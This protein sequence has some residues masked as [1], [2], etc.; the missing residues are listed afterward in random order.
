ML[1]GFECPSYSRIKIS[2]YVAARGKAAHAEKKPRPPIRERF[3][4]SEGV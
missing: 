1:D 2:T 3:V 4:S